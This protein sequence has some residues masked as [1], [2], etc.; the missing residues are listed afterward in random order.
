VPLVLLVPYAAAQAPPTTLKER[1]KL[2]D[3]RRIG[4]TNLELGLAGIA[5]GPVNRVWFSPSG[6]QLFVRCRRVTYTTS[7]FERWSP[8]SAEAPSP[9]AASAPTTPEP[10]AIVRQAQSD[11]M[12]AAGRNAWRSD[13][14]G[15]N[16]R[17][18]TSYQGKSIL[19][20]ALADLAVSP[21]NPDD[22]VV[23]G[24]SGVWRS[25]DG[26]LSWIS[27]NHGLPNLPVRK[28]TISP[29][30]G[31][32]IQ[33]DGMNAAEWLPGE[34]VA[35]RAIG[36]SA[37]LL[38]SYLR[39]R[40]SQ[41][42]RAEVTAFASSGRIQYAGSSDGRLFV[43]DDN[44]RTVQ[45][46]PTGNSA[47]VARIIADARDPKF[48]V[49][50]L[51]GTGRARVLRT[52]NGG[53]FWEDLSE[54][55]PAAILHSVAADR[56]SGSLYVAGDLG[57]FYA[58]GDLTGPLSMPW[59]PVRSMKDAAAVDVALDASASQLYAA[60][61]GEGVFASM[62]PH[63][64]RDPRVLSAGDLQ[65]R[66]A[67]PGALLSVA[68]SR[69]TSA[70]SEAGQVPV[71]SAAETQSQVQVPFGAEGDSIQLFVEANQGRLAFEM[72]LRK[73]APSIFVDR[74]GLPLVMNADSGLMLDAGTPARS[75]SRLQIFATGLGR[76]QPDWPAG[77]PA[78]S[79]EPPKVA[80]RIRVLLDREEVPV[81]RAMLAPGYVGLYLVEIQLPE[82]VNLG[83]AELY[84]E[85]EGQESNRV[86]IFL[87]R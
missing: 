57:I 33:I 69:V 15:I 58:H 62:A 41:A 7:D 34:R 68:G 6:D 8:A 64:L 36:D 60:F 39:N 50:V 21:A 67:A 29:Q 42:L 24:G 53:A 44:W 3:W 54:G 31:V 66:H 1:I 61:E 85:M 63:R 12:Y 30:G 25:L 77:V 55:L 26:G 51:G 70:W 17:N 46:F 28:L 52:N 23:A 4:N 49:A 2:L 73:T 47:S 11:R 87:E 80:G 79:E 83:P 74:D 10:G 13:D 81:T 59:V 20:E 72:P 84:V 18:V 32:R 56:A 5:S 40:A 75:G 38:E 86:R 27:I 9:S 35:W 78:P 48:A 82:V 65:M 19:G 16:W 22:I 71:L 45:T 14:G 37:A 43:S 76:V